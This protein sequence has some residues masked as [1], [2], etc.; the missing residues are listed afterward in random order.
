MVVEGGV[1][2][3]GVEGQSWLAWEVEGQVTLDFLLSTPC[4][5]PLLNARLRRS[6]NGIYIIAYFI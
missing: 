5:T 6:I 1:V 4:G 2:G 3:G